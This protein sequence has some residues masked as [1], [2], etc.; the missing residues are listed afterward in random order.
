MSQPFSEDIKEQMK[1]YFN[2]YNEE[3]KTKYFSHNYVDSDFIYFGRLNHPL[4]NLIVKY[5]IVALV[6]FGKEG[7]LDVLKKL[8]MQNA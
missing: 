3:F 6:A 8:Q 4:C 5:Q 7:G 2:C 1:Q